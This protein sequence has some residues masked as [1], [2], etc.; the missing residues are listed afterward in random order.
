MGDLMPAI[1]CRAACAAL[2]R[3]VPDALALVTKNFGAGNSA[4]ASFPCGL[5][6]ARPPLAECPDVPSRTWPITLHRAR[7][8]RRSRQPGAR[9]ARSRGIGRWIGH[10]LLAVR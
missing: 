4:I 8:A 6:R 7:C 9:V 10:T 3:S 5:A 1:L 2:V